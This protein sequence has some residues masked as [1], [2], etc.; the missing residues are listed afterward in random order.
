MLRWLQKRETFDVVTP[1]EWVKQ[2]EQHQHTEHPALKLLGLWKDAYCNSNS[3]KS[4]RPQF[5]M[6]ETKK[7]VPVLRN[8]QPVSEEYMARIWT[9]VQE[10][11]H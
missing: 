7:H 5:A 3:E 11:V 9:W 1:D 10:N 4:F 2:L 6:E 8:V